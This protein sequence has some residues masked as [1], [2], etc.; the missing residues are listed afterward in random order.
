MLILEEQ[1]RKMTDKQKKYNEDLRKKVDEWRAKKDEED[2]QKEQQLEND[3]KHRQEEEKAKQDKYEEQRMQI[4]EYKKQLRDKNRDTLQKIKDNR[5]MG[6]LNKLKDE[7]VL[8]KIDLGNDY[9]LPQIVRTIEMV[10]EE[11]QICER[12]RHKHKFDLRKQPRSRRAT[13]KSPYIK[14]NQFM[15]DDGNHS[16]SQRHFFSP[17]HPR[18]TTKIY[19]EKRY[20]I[21]NGMP[22]KKK[23]KHCHPHKS[24]IDEYVSMRA[25]QVRLQREGKEHS[26]NPNSNTNQSQNQTQSVM[27]QHHE[28]KYTDEKVADNFMSYNKEKQQYK[29]NTVENKTATNFKP[30]KQF[31]SAV[32]KPSFKSSKHLTVYKKSPTSKQRK[33]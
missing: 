31:K 2:R 30:S 16:K 11:K 19:S 10:E 15:L 7:T 22:P 33:F 25:E 4:E 23:Q 5:P 18:D 9:H 21:V 26:D 20:V 12:F 3:Y 1:D 8:E 17:Q 14:R 28:P 6:P 29:E 24:V 32:V 13:K 27:S